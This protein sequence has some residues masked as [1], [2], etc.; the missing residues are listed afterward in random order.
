MLIVYDKTTEK[1]VGHCSQVFDAGKWREAT[2]EELY[3]NQDRSKLATAYMPDDARFVGYGVNNWKLR[4]DENG[5]V[6][7]IERLPVLSLQSDAPDT[8]NDG[9]PDLPADGKSVAHVNVSTSDGTDTEVTFRTSRGSLNLR[10][11]K[12]AAGKATVEI[13]S[14]TETVPAII[15]ATATGYRPAKLTL[16]F[17]PVAIQAG[18]QAV[19]SD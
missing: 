4:K 7:G 12:T 2:L 17:T 14:A 3:P 13:R 10:S 19:L 8:D 18:G 15:T 5:V 9:V 11:A 1:I 16:E 6:M